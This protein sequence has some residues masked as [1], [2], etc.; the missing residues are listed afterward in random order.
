MQP[1]IIVVQFAVIALLVVAIAIVWLRTRRGSVQVAEPKVAPPMSLAQLELYSQ[2]EANALVIGPLDRP[3]VMV[4]P[5]VPQEIDNSQPLE[6]RRDQIAGLETLV[7]H[8]PSLA[9]A[10]VNTV[11]QTYVVRFAPEIASK[12]ATGS[13][14]FM[15]SLEGGTRAIA[16][17]VDGRILGHGT[18]VPSGLNAVA[19][20]TIVWQLLAVVTA[21]YYLVGINRRLGAI[22]ERLDA[23][24]QRLD[25]QDEAMLVNNF[26]RLKSI[27]AGLAHGALTDLDV[28]SFVGEVDTID[29]ECGRIMEMYLIAMS[30]DFN[31]L[32][33]ASLKGTFDPEN[34][35]R[36]AR[37]QVDEYTRSAQMC[38][39]AAAARVAAAEVRCA[40]PVDIGIAQRRLSDIQDELDRWQ[41]DRQA[42]TKM[43]KSR[44][45]DVS[46]TIRLKWWEHDR[47]HR[48]K[49]LR[50][51][52]QAKSQLTDGYTALKR[53]LDDVKQ[54]ANEY[55][56]LQTQSLNLLVD[57]NSRGEVSNVRRLVE[58]KA[59]SEPHVAEAAQ[60]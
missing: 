47:D 45:Q 58:R 42:F 1:I 57:I 17:G 29:R 7:R 2:P 18:L 22:E 27:H 51:E 55:Q 35:V 54:R 9:I 46:T 6:L 19:A 20:A 59:A 24:H 10:S 34:E 21:Q 32:Q 14:S 23:L 16:V 44:A 3:A 4:Q 25:D 37:R 15:P 40:L 53:G 28:Q 26:K 11:S 43:V 38:T 12:L 36:A 33:T 49:L 13:A 41:K 52:N 39:M 5:Y 50:A 30:R 60:R 56:A 31:R 8:V 48:S